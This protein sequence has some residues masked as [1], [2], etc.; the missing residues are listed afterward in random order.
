MSDL[1]PEQPME[2]VVGEPAEPAWGGPSQEEWGEVQS[3]LGQLAQYLNQQA[4]P[5]PT[6]EGYPQIDPFSDEFG[7]QIAQYVQQAVQQAIAPVTD[8]QYQQQ[9]SEAEERALD[10]IEDDVSRNGEFMLGEKA[11]EGVRALANVYFQ[12]EAQRYGNTP[13][14]AEAAIQRASATWREYE[15]ELAAK[16]VEQHSNQL[17]TL[18]TAR[19][20]PGIAGP[21]GQIA[22]GSRTIEELI[23]KYV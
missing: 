20:E 2:E 12:D 5:E 23:S 4:Q 10:I 6:D 16:A 19:R 13:K 11:F 17:S 8:W 22:Q 1:I 9:L 14:A 3:Q 21:A 7:P 15:K 18:G